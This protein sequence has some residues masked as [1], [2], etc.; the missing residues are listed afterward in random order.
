MLVER[1]G[2]LASLA[3]G[4]EQATA[5]HGRLV[6]IGGEAG[7]GKTSVVSAFA[8]EVP[9]DVHVRR[10][11]ID[12]LTTPVALGALVE[13]VPELSD[14]VDTGGSIDRPRLFRRLRDAIAD[15]PTVL[16]LEDVHWADEATLEI[17]RFLGRRLDGLQLLTLATFR[18]EEVSPRHRLAAA[19]GDLATA[20][21]VERVA[22]EPLSATAVRTL[23]AKSG[24]AIDPEHLHERTGGNAFYVTEVLAA[25][26]DDVPATVRDAV[27]SRLTRLS[28]SARDVLA[29]AAVLGQPSDAQLL[30]DVAGQPVDSVDEC[31]DHGLLVSERAGWAFRHELARVAVENTVTP[32]Q[33]TALHRRAFAA[34]TERRVDDDR[35]LAHHASV[36]GERASAAQHALRAAERAARL[37]AHREAV[38]Q[39][40]LALRFH[41]GDPAGREQLLVALSYECYLTGDPEDALTARSKAMELAELAGTPQSLGQHQRWISRLSWFLGRNADSERYALRAIATLEPEGDG[42]ELAMAYS[43]KAQLCMLSGDADGAESWGNRALGMARRIGD[44]DVEI[45]ALNNVGT[46]LLQSDRPLEGWTQLHR[47]LDLAL[48]DDAHEH[49]ARAYTNLASMAVTTRRLGDA[50]DVLRAGITYCTDRDLDAWRLYMEAHLARALA[51]QGLYDE[52]DAVA[53]DVLRHLHLSPITAIVARVAAAQIAARRGADADGLLTTAWDLARGTGEAQRLVPVAAALAEAH[54]LAGLDPPTAALDIAWTSA[55]GHPVA[56][57]LGEIAFWRDLAGLPAESPAPLPE[58]FA[59][60]LAGRLEAAADAWRVLGCPLWRAYALARDPSVEAGREAFTIADELGA[61]AVRGAFVQLRHSRGLAVP[62]GPRGAATDNPAALTAR[63]LEV[64]RLIADGLSNAEIA[65]GLFLSEKTV[66]HHVSS[67][68]RKVGEPSRGRAAA[69]AMQHGLIET[70]PEST[71]VPG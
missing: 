46:A 5:G 3:A 14:L 39:Y 30:A 69:W 37:G 20:P 8:A 44:R 26:G 67:I 36:A 32:A 13:A 21:G 40:R 41:S 16:I 1:E 22:V 33:A 2:C 24:A 55:V 62:R 7:V 6:F 68:L 49:A 65:A 59:L 23:V 58:P 48:A 19:M 27:L 43:N 45:H 15:A 53:H 52:A 31:V 29:A 42:H 4:L 11:F 66:G 63:E 61:S 47:S 9:T 51:E 60:M 54:W 18:S 70:M 10:G 71:D 50:E 35:L 28:V 64:L 34:L 17:L 12:N 25:P 56:W 57:E 38:E